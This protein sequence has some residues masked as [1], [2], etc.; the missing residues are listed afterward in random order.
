MLV[1]IILGLVLLGGI[2]LCIWGD[3]GG[4]DGEEAATT[5][6]ATLALVSSIAIIILLTEVSWKRD[7]EFDKAKYEELKRETIQLSNM[8]SSECDLNIL[9]KKD[10]FEEVRK[11]NNYIDKNKYY[12][13]SLWL[14]WFYSEEIGNLPKL[15]YVPPKPY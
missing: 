14:N 13:N 7:I 15:D 5:L 1:F 8:S 9:A 4:Y 12:S 2:A 10:L 6:G 11:M 3:F